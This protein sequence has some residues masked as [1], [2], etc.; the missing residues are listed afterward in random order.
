MPIVVSVLLLTQP[1]VPMARPHIIWSAAT[2]PPYTP[3][4]PLR[5]LLISSSLYLS[6]PSLHPH[7]RLSSPPLP[8]ALSHSS[9][10]HTEPHCVCVLQ[11]TQSGL[12][13][14]THTHPTG[15]VHSRSDAYTHIHITL[16]KTNRHAFMCARDRKHTHTL[17]FICAHWIHTHLHTQDVSHRGRDSSI[18][19]SFFFFLFYSF[20]LQ[21]FHSVLGVWSFNLLSIVI[22]LSSSVPTVGQMIW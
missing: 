20:M 4:E 13:S 5:V 14:D 19:I 12:I 16:H 21:F 18:L 3:L 9:G 7:P 22:F 1:L 8:G 10:L 2:Q 15:C 17:I 6:A 11:S